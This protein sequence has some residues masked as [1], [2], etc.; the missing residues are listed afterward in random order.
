MSSK[1]ITEKP[2]SSPPQGD[3][4]PTRETAPS[5][6]RVDEPS[7]GRIIGFIG[8][9]LLALGGTALLLHA[10]NWT[11]G[12]GPFW[13]SLAVIAGMAG[14]LFHAACDSET[15]VRR[16]YGLVG[17]LWLAV[18]ALVSVLPIKGPAFSAFLPYGF[19]C[20]VLGLLFLLPFVR[21]ETDA[22]LRQIA[23]YTLGG[24]GAT[25]ALI[26]FL[27]SNLWS[28]HLAEGM[29]LTLVG[30]AFLWGFIGLSGANSDV[31]YKAALAACAV[32]LV[33]FLIAFIRSL[34]TSSDLYLVPDGLVL[35]GLG[36]LYAVFGASFFLENRF[37]VLTRRELAAFF[38][39]PIAYIVLLGLTLVGCWYF[40]QF[41]WTLRTAALDNQSLI[42][43]IISYYLLDIWPIICV[44]FIVPVLTMRLMSEEL[45]TGT[46]EVL[47]TA[48]LGEVPVVLSK[49]TAA[50][51]FYLL[52][53]LPW[54]LFLIALR[55]G[56]GEPFEY[57]PL[58]GFYIML[59]CTGANFLAMGLFFSSL[60]RNQIIAAVATFGGMLFL[61]SLFFI[62]RSLQ[63]GQ[64]PVS[65]AWV[66]VLT[67]VNF[68]DVWWQSLEGKL[69]LQGLLFQVSSA[70]FWLFLT[71]KV[72]ESR[73]WR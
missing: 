25:L 67:H 5:L 60:T 24:V 72:L 46:M 29:L 8:L 22:K 73:K 61:T 16:V 20:F 31:G 13:G 33:I 65:S 26:G 59:A 71:L 2:E 41:I 70:V 28:A 34:A 47:F 37:V 48:P 40:A 45:R 54:G 69:P 18:G 52:L 42:E 38:Y 9:M 27:V 6:T 63:G 35:M 17:F 19:S 23:L 66:P 36:A 3:W 62:K 7:F 1:A 43:P 21:H 15:Q 49:F 68:I 58:L 44:I 39:S 51:I 64:T 55:V 57:R 10:A 53:W 4:Q 30:L 11:R 50:L 56:N 14:L 12:I 32:G